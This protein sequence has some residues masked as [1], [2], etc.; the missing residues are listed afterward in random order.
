MSHPLFVEN[1]ILFLQRKNFLQ[2][3]DSHAFS[4]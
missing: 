4:Q 3:T 1:L 2:L